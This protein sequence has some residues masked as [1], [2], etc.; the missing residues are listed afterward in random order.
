MSEEILEEIQHE[1]LN[2]KDIILSVS[3]SSTE[4]GIVNAIESLSNRFTQIESNI[5]DIQDQILQIKN[6]LDDIESAVNK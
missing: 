1:I 5:S 2:L 3:A 6:Q 4:T